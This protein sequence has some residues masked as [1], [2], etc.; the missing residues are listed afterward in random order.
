MHYSVLI[1]LQFTDFLNF[2]CE[3]SCRAYGSHQEIWTLEI[4]N[5]LEGPDGDR[6]A[7]CTAT[8]EVSGFAVAA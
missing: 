2:S 4:K 3:F 8:S 5:G 6:M 1:Y 7:S